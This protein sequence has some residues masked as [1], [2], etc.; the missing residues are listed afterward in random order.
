M[1]YLSQIYKVSSGG[2]NPIGI[3]EYYNNDESQFTKGVSGVPNRGS[4]IS[5]QQFYGK[6][7]RVWSLPVE[8]TFTNFDA[9][10]W[11]LGNTSIMWLTGASGVNS[12][13][14]NGSTFNNIGSSGANRANFINCQNLILEAMPGDTL[15]FHMSIGANANYFTLASLLINL[16]KGWFLVAAPHGNGSHT[17]AATYTIPTTTAPG[18]YGIAIYCDYD[19]ASSA[20]WSSANFYSLQVVNN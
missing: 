14:T 20:T 8:S 13:R 3:N 19:H 11:G 7:K 16:G 17:K 2:A 18:N 10:P 9:I 4:S 6:V 12:T 1:R 15:T 5:L